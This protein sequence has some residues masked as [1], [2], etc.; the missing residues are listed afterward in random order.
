MYL[1][2]K[3]RNSKKKMSAGPTD[4]NE[5][6]I[7]SINHTES[8]LTVASIHQSPQVQGMSDLIL[9]MLHKLDESN[10]ALIRF[11]SDLE[12]QKILT[13]KNPVKFSYN[14]MFQLSLHRTIFI[15]WHLHIRI[16]SNRPHQTQQHALAV[17]NS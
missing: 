13:I 5:S 15:H 12:S 4:L 17:P 3:L 14:L 11:V 6:F 10:Q 16:A 7:Q 8:D 1:F 9:A 2:R